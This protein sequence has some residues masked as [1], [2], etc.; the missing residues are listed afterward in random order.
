M[1]LWSLWKSRNSKL[2][3]GTN[4]PPESI[5]LWA[6]NSLQEWI[7]MQKARQPSQGTH[8]EVLWEKPPPL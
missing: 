3:E 2:W 7:R 1:I 8:Q 5:V 6:K 4:T